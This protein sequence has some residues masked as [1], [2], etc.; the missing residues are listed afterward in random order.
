MGLS[1]PFPLAHSPMLT[2]VLERIEQV[3]EIPVRYGL[4]EHGAVRK[5][6]IQRVVPLRPPNAHIAQQD[7]PRGRVECRL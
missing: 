5:G 6:N 3:S 1:Y 4:S 7:H 2:Q